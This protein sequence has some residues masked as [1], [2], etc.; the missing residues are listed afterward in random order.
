MQEVLRILRGEK[1]SDIQ[2]ERKKRE[3][4]IVAICV[5]GALA[6]LGLALAKSG[7]AVV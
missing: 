3:E 7:R 6:A 5:F 2:A 4:Q 1:W